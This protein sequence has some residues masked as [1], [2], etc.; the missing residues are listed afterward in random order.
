MAMTPKMAPPHFIKLLLTV[1]QPNRLILKHNKKITE[2]IIIFNESYVFLIYLCKRIF[3]CAI[4]MKSPI[5]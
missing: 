4:P 1:T 2:K 3:I 5:P